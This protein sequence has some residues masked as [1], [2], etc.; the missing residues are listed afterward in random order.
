MEKSN[1]PE[2]IVVESKGSV[3]ANVAG[4]TNDTPK[5][6]SCVCVNR[7]IAADIGGNKLDISI[8]Q[9]RFNRTDSG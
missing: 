1:T 2:L 7:V 9:T 4:Q 3:D 5:I 6:C 8:L